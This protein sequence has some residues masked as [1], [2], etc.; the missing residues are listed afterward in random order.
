MISIFFEGKPILVAFRCDIRD[1]ENPIWS[2]AFSE[3][4]GASW[5]WNW[6]MFMSKAK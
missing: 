2:Q 1:K 5:E 6:H 3:D 4:N